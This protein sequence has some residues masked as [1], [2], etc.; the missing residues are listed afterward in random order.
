MFQH[1][2]PGVDVCSDSGHTTLNDKWREIGNGGSGN[3]DQGLPE[4]WYKFQINGKPAQIPTL[5]IKVTFL[6]GY[7]RVNIGHMAIVFDNGTQSP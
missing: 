2:S 1:V 7:Y 5:C 6:S 3:C 4:G